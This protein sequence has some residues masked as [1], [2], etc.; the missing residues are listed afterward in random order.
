MKLTKHLDESQEVFFHKEFQPKRS[1]VYCYFVEKKYAN[2]SSKK[3]EEKRALYEI[4]FASDIQRFY[5]Y[6]G[7]KDIY[8]FL[9]FTNQN[10]LEVAIFQPS[11]RKAALNRKFYYFPLQDL[12][13]YLTPPVPKRINIDETPKKVIYEP[14]KDKKI[15][16][17]IFLED[18]QPIDNLFYCYFEEKDIPSRF[19]SSNHLHNFSFAYQTVF[20]IQRFV[21]HPRL[22]K[23]FTF[24]GFLT[25]V[26]MMCAL[27]NKK[28]QS[29]AKNNEIFIY[30]KNPE[31]FI[32]GQSEVEPINYN[33]V[34]NQYLNSANISIGTC[35][36]NIFLGLK[37]GSF[38]KNPIQN[39]I[40]NLIE[41][42]N[43]QNFVPKENLIYI[44]YI[45][46]SF[47][48]Q[49]TFKK[50]GILNCLINCRDIQ[51]YCHFPHS[52][53]VCS[54]FGFSNFL[55]LKNNFRR[56]SNTTQ[57]WIYPYLNLSNEITVENNDMEVT[58]LREFVPK[59]ELIYFYFHENHKE[60][61]SE[62]PWGK[63]FQSFYAIYNAE[64]IQ[65]SCY[66]PGTN[67]I[68]SFYGFKSK[69]LLLKAIKHSTFEFKDIYNLKIYNKKDKNV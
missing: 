7:T 22:Q 64:D 51:Q 27:Q 29:S 10:Q 8:T 15:S 17:F 68:Y 49:I 1:F 30:K 28:L 32:I 14:A 6:P 43:F 25:R 11:L 65:S 40:G 62:N 56:L 9:G 54:F 19:L 45:E 61:K 39:L 20:D 55:D 35:H 69:K 48:C 18:F 2:I 3:S 36:R 24:F 4:T 60:N 63:V 16:L 58:E 23:V 66:Y 50:I 67:K 21:Y 52:K 31:N 37:F 38:I 33:N 53:V 13:S 47:P 12:P 41:L 44:C 46:K 26:Q 59:K 5:Y 34:T 57:V 42:S